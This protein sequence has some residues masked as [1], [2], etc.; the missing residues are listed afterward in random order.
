M[1]A[2]LGLRW[3]EQTRMELYAGRIQERSG[4][5]VC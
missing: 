1:K 3:F 4:N 2:L 5:Q